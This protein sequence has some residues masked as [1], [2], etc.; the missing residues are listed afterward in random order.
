MRSNVVF[1]RKTSRVWMAVYLLVMLIASNSK[2]QELSAVQTA[3]EG[4][5]TLLQTVLDSRE[6]FQS[7]REAYF[8]RIEDVLV[9]FV[10]F[11][12]VTNVVMSQHA[13][14]ATEEQKQR[15]AD[16]LK[17]TLTRFYGASLASYSGEE[18]IFLPQTNPNAAPRAD[19]VVR[20]ELLGNEPLQLQ[21]QMFL[22]DNDEWKLK[23]IRL[24]GINLGR[25][26]NTQF[27]FLMS[28]HEND[29]DAVLDNWK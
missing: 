15:F 20:M 23:N 2:A 13:D 3:E 24:A 10:D 4:V 17:S 21:Y 26:Y 16:I 1:G 18:L 11:T 12:A 14:N 28:E 6:L 19:T 7:D 29:I 9:S 27:N 8:T 22:N 5:T 25:Q